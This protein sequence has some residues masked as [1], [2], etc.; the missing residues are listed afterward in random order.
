MCLCVCA[1]VC[2]VALQVRVYL[3]MCVHEHVCVC[4]N[5]TRLPSE[6]KLCYFKEENSFQPVI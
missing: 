4:E 3:Y 5:N 2:R 6:Q 1:S